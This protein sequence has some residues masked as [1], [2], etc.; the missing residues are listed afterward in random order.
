[1]NKQIL[2]RIIVESLLYEGSKIREKIRNGEYNPEFFRQRGMYPSQEEILAGINRGNQNRIKQYCDK[3]G[4]EVVNHKPFMNPGSGVRPIFNLKSTIQSVKDGKT[5]E[6]SKKV[7]LDKNSSPIEVAHELDEIAFDKNKKFSLPSQITDSEKILN[8]VGKRYEK[9][10]MFKFAKNGIP[11]AIKRY[12]QQAKGNFRIQLP[13]GRWINIGHVSPEVLR[14]EGE[15]LNQVGFGNNQVDAIRN[16]RHLS[17]EDVLQ[18]QNVSKDKFNKTLKGLT[19]N[20]DVVRIK[21]PDGVT[22]D[23]YKRAIKKVKQ[24]KK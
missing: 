2:K 10:G 12:K 18:D 20:N 6:F 17:G 7:M 24:Q 21:H 14:R 8:D 3:Y 19:Q 11:Y 16:F 4:I 22:M 23:D 13:D 1:M 9:G 15:R 5:P